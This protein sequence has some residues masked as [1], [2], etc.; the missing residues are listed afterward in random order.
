MIL[1]FSGGIDSFVAYHY[2]KEP[3]TIYFDIGS[4]YAQ[5]EINNVMKIAPNT[6]IDRTFP[7]LGEDDTEDD[8]AYIPYRNLFFAMRA[9]YYDPHVVIAGVKDDQVSDKNE[10]VFR[11]FSCMLSSLEGKEIRVTSPFWD[12]TKA[13]VVRWFIENMAHPHAILST[14]SCYSEED[15][16]YCGRCRCCFRKWNA[17]VLNGFEVAFHNKEMAIGYK[18][19]A[20]SDKYI[21][22]RNEGILEALEVY[23]GPDL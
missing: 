17:L 3:P 15:T 2:L 10:R 23:Y 21:P 4:P 22:E 8:N 9:S 5:K 14:V 12:L 20:L 11:E 13:D 16:T 6:I 7:F 18:E 19:A 1:C